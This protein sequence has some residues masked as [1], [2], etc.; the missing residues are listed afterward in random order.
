MLS[1]LGATSLPLDEIR[2]KE[3]WRTR[4][5]SQPNSPETLLALGYYQYCV[6]RDYGLA[7]TTFGLVGR[8]LPGSSEVSAALAFVARREGHWDESVVNWEQPSPSIRGRGVTESNGMDLHHASKFPTALK[9]HDRA[10]DIV[11]NEPGVMA[12]KA[13]IHLAEGN[14]EQAG[15]FLSQIDAEDS[16]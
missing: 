15:K 2:L 8:M 11:P 9:L 6:L 4:R 5:N 16:I 1:L 12:V 10:L 14:L 7:K 13:N 3:R